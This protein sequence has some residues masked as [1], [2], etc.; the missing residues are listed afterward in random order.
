M[1]GLKAA[2]WIVLPLPIVYQAAICLVAPLLVAAIPVL[3]GARITVREAISSYGLSGGGGWIDG[4]LARLRGLPRVVSLA[5]TNA[6][7]NLGRVSTTQLALAGA[8]MTFMAVL[9]A[10]ASLIYTLSGVLLQAYP[11]QIQLDLTKTASLP[12]IAQASQVPGVTAI[13]GWRQQPATVRQADAPE[14]ATDPAMN[15]SGVPVPTASYMPVLLKGRTLQPGDTYALVLHEWLAKDAGVTVGDWVLVSIPDPTNTKRWISQQRWQVVGVLIDASMRGGALAPQQTLFDEI[16]RREV[17]R[18]Q[19]QSADLSAEATA[20]LA[21]QLRTFYA[22]QGMDVQL[23]RL[24]TVAQRSQ[25]QLDNLAAVIGLLLLVALIVAGVGAISLN[26]TLS[27]SVLERRREIGVLRA[28]GAT[29]GSIRTQFVIEGLVMSML[30]WLI[31]LVFSYPVGYLTAQL[32]AASLRISVIY[33]Y[34]WL[35]VWIWLALATI[36]AII[37]SL[38][39]AQQAIRMSVQESLAYE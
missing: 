28:I 16:G 3:Q 33:Q 30:S 26:G 34:S 29:P 6:F 8:G 21:T 27:I 35:G 7:R 32:V 24:A 38:S 10:R 9:S 36:I 37:A 18:I 13:E 23:S 4:L 5:L 15:I 1:L 19:V 20:A 31:G 2:D 22:D 11:Y 17:N 39:P 14:Q 25:S 12:R